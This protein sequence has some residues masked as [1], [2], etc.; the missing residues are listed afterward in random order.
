[1]ASAGTVTLD[2]DANSVKMIR[3]LQKAQRQTKRTATRM[4]GDMGKALGGIAKAAA[5][6][7]IAL[8]AAFATG[9]VRNTIE[10]QKAVAQ[11]NA[12]LESTGRYSE[13]V[14]ESLQKQASAL[15][16]VS[17][18][19]DD[20]II[21][22]QSL[23][24][25]FKQLGGEVFPRT[26]QAVL[27]MSAK[28]GTDLKSSAIQLGKA[29][30]DPATGLSMLT[31][32]GITFSE[33]QKKVIKSFVE[34]N[35]LAKAQDV[36]LTELE[37]QFGGAALAARKTFGGALTA[38]KNNFGDLLEVSGDD[39]SGVVGSLNDL[40]DTL[41]RPEVKQGFQTLAQDALELLSALAQ[42]P[43]TFGYLADEVRA[44]FGIIRQN[45]VVRLYEQLYDLNQE[46][47]VAEG[48]NFFGVTWE[49]KAKILRKEIEAIQ[50]LL[51]AAA[52]NKQPTAAMFGLTSPGGGEPDVT[53]PPVVTTGT[54]IDPPAVQ[55]D[56]DKVE[57]IIQKMLDDI[58][59]F[60][61]TDDE[62]VLF[63]L[64]DQGATE[65]QIAQIR[66]AQDEMRIL[67]EQEEIANA[68]LEEIVVTAK[69]IGP[70]VEEASE[71]MTQFAIQAARSMQSALA[72]FLFDPFDEGLKG[73]LK[74]FAQTIK[75][76]VAEALAAQ[77]L[78]S[79]FGGASGSSNPWLAA[80]SSAF[81]GGKAVGGPVNA[82][83]A[84]LVGEKG[85]EI[86][87]MGGASGNIIP[88]HQIAAANGNSITNIV[89]LPPTVQR[90]T[91]AQVAFEVSRIQKRSTS[92]NA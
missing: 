91:A 7:G 63:K 71:E 64:I 38:L 29:L 9:V 28:M 76:M 40:A 8:G 41:A 56:A 85:P 84:Y 48:D 3:E 43:A 47:K 46:L 2:L 24:L 44:F 70:A 10:Q 20:A 17:T 42:L 16:Q 12:S 67:K 83:R 80:I 14:S 55:A 23:L 37:S 15:Q 87:Q 74:G 21:T 4:A 19:G 18:F 1:M 45:D 34:T 79:I 69:K 78:K 73:M 81:S 13:A 72:D 66:I 68:E 32:V 27:D 88:N 62:K 77:I 11:L 5:T 31:R 54:V 60:G 36:I 89:N 39:S 30:N 50:K 57:E 58:A 26:T 6:M 61:M 22:A 86:L 53:I 75:R 59:T 33:E 49:E 92:R 52:F 25:T 90:Q 82:N 51:D 65:E 35:Q